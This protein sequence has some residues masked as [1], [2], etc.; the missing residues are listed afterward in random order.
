M[1]LSAMRTD[2]TKE[3]EGAWIDCEE[4]LRLKIARHG[5]VKY[6]EAIRTLSV[7]YQRRLMNNTLSQATMEEIECKAMANHILKG[8]ENLQDDDGKEIP[9]TP[10]KAFELLTT[11]RD[12]FKMVRALAQ[13]A[14]NYRTEVIK[15]AVGN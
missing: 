6:D 8:W 10:E 15:E 11:V 13:N 7:P 4:G 9:Y 2:S 12:F 3:V 1:K 14:D 5:N